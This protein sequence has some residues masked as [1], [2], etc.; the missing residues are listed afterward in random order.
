MLIATHLELTNIG[1]FLGSQIVELDRECTV[2]TGPNDV[3]KTWILRAF[4][5]FV[6]GKPVQELEVNL[7][8]LKTDSPDWKT[9][10]AISIAVQFLYDNEE[11]DLVLDIDGRKFRL[12]KGKRERFRVVYF[13]AP[14]LNKHQVE[15]GD[16]RHVVA[17]RSPVVELVPLK[18]AELLDDGLEIGHGDGISILSQRLL[19][20]AFGEKGRFQKIL[21]SLKLQHVRTSRIDAANSRLNDLFQEAL[22]TFKQRLKFVEISPTAFRLDIQEGKDDSTPLMYR[23]IGFKKLLSFRRQVY[24]SQTVNRPLRVVLC[25]EPESSLHPAAQHHLRAAFEQLCKGSPLQMIYV[26]HSPSMINRLNPASVRVVRR[27]QT[28]HEIGLELSRSQVDKY[29]PGDNFLS[30]RTSLGLSAADSLLYAPI[31]VVVEGDTELVCLERLLRLV[32]V[33]AEEIAALSLT[34]LMDG[35]GAPNLLQWCHRVESFGDTAIAFADGDKRIDIER[36]C[37]KNDYR[38]AVVLI[39]DGREFEDLVNPRYYFE[40]LSV[41]CETELKIEDFE[42]WESHQPEWFQR[43]AF[44]KKLEDWVKAERSDVRYTKQMVMENAVLRDGELLHWDVEPIKRLLAAIVRA[45]VSKCLLLGSGEKLDSF[46][47]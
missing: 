3:G 30:V 29:L 8:Y 21:E 41:T 6:L 38:F 31:V 9:D 10:S 26:T 13:A 11:E 12:T 45:A 42:E 7:Q 39:N 25:D 5:H 18:A 36:E 19:D 43:K 33:S 44:S 35:K 4:E 24:F 14:G 1:P 28:R 20:Y 27:E 47:S 15:M 17:G 16:V 37:R 46:E 23:S 2:I 32:A 40:C 22:P 34:V